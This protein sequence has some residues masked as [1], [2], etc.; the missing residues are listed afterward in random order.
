MRTAIATLLLLM[1]PALASAQFVPNA[2]TFG[3]AYVSGPPFGFPWLST[4]ETNYSLTV[5]GF[6]TAVQAPLKDLIPDG[7][8]EL[9]FVFSGAHSSSVG[10]FDGSCTD[11]NYWAFNSSTLNVYL[12]TTPDGDFSNP[13]TFT[14]GEKVLTAEVSPT[15]VKDDDPAESCPMIEDSP[16]VFAQML[17]TGGTWYAHVS[18]G[19]IGYYANERGEIAG[20]SPDVPPALQAIGYVL[21]IDGEI[22]IWFPIMT[23][24]ASTWGAVKSMYR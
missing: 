19:G 22:D 2:M 23:T 4:P 13:G 1:V 24:R 10:Y 17:F 7:T 16:D 21:R 12:D 18:D 15:S 14:D 6:I 3:P 11:G 9:T 8:F 5:I 20:H